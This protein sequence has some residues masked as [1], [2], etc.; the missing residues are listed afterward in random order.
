MRLACR[1]LGV[2]GMIPP[3]F[4]RH[5]LTT[6]FCVAQ[7]EEI[8]DRDVLLFSLV[9]CV[10]LLKV[11]PPLSCEVLRC[12]IFGRFGWVSGNPHQHNNV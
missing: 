2:N 3:L 8:A 1:L 4:S 12:V 10:R 6:A 5:S 7:T 9:T 11:C